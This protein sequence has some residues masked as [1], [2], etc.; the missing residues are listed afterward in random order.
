MGAMP[1]IM[2][3]QMPPIQGHMGAHGGMGPHGGMGG[4]HGGYEPHD[5]RYEPDDDG[6][7]G[8]AAGYDGYGAAGRRGYDGG[9]YEARPHAAPVLSVRSLCT[10]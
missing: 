3:P 6:G 7:Y 9:W 1:G 10:L 2:Q 4:A 5:G 8:R